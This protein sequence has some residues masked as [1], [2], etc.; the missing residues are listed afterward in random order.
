M[1]HRQL[2]C[3]H[4]L[5][6]HGGEDGGDLECLA[7]HQDRLLSAGGNGDNGEIKVWQS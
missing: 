3:E 1:E 2:T 7:M 5:E 4:T 6:G